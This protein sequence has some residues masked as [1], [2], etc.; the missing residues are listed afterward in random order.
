MNALEAY[1]S[2]DRIGKRVVLAGGGLVGCE[3]GL[4]LAEHGHDVTVVEMQGMMAFE[5]TVAYLREN[6]PDQFIIADAKRGDIGN[7]SEMYAR[8]F[9]DHIKVDAVTV[10]PVYGRG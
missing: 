4:H 6:Y 5:K 1:H 10:A 7:T 9:F 2:M 3:V 8:S